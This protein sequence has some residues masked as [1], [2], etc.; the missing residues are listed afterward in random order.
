MAK[1]DDMVC[2]CNL[3]L[4]EELFTVYCYVSYLVETQAHFRIENKTQQVIN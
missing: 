3:S 1:A 4:K 2:R